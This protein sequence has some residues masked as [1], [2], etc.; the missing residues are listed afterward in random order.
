MTRPSALSRASTGHRAL[1]NG[2]RDSG[3]RI[4][5]F[6]MERILGAEELVDV[7]HIYHQVCKYTK[8]NVSWLIPWGVDSS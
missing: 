2:L 1:H 3:V 5:G 7:P 8:I 4:S 6:E